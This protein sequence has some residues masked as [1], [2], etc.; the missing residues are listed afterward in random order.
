M[1]SQINIQNRLALV[2]WGSV[3]LAYL[4]AAVG[5]A[6]YQSVTLESRAQRIM[7]PYAQ[8]ISVGSDAAI[9]FQDPQRA[10][11]VLDTLR[12]NPQILQA[13][14]YLDNGHILA[15]FSH[16]DK[17][18][19]HITTQR[20]DGIYIEENRVE[21][22]QSLHSGAHLLISMDLAQL[23]EQ[24]R[25]AIWLFAAGAFILLLASIAQFAVLR[26]MIVQ[27]IATLTR[28]AEH[29]RSSADFK[30]RVPASG[31]DEVARLGQSF[32]AMM[33]VIHEKQQLLLEA[34][35]IA[36]VGNWWHDPNSGE[37]FW[38][39][40]VFNI[41][42]LDALTPS[43]ELVYQLIHH[44]DIEILQKAIRLSQ[45]SHEDSEQEFRILR[46]NGETRWV[47]NRWVS[48]FDNNGRVIKQIGTLQDITERKE[49]EQALHQL[50]RELRAI[51]EC[52]HI[53]IRAEQEQ[54]LI[55]SVCRII[56]E[57]AGYRLAWVGYAEH[58]TAK[59]IRPVAWAG[60][61]DGY[62]AQVPINWDD[63]AYG[64]GP[65]GL[66]IR[67][68][69]IHVVDDFTTDPGTRPWQQAALQRG[70]NSSISLPLKNDCGVTFGVLGIFS[71]ASNAFPEPEQRLLEELANDLAFG[72]DTLRTRA[73][74]NQAEEQIRIAATAFEAQEGII[75]ADVNRQILR[76][77]RAFTE[78]SGYSAQEVMGKTPQLLKS[79]KHDEEFFSAMWQSLVKE[80]VWQG[81]IWN[82]DKQGDD[83]PVWLNIT[84]VRDPSGQVTHYVGTMTDITERKEAEKKIEHL[85]YYDLLTELPNRR[86]LLDR[87]RQASL[88]SLRSKNMGA[89][90]FI[91]L[92]NFKILNDTSGHDIGDKLLIGVAR[93]LGSCVRDGDTISRLGGDE[94]VVILEDLSQT[95]AEAAAHAK[96]IG[97]KIISILNQ[98]YQIEDRMHHSTPSIGIT[99]FNG[100]ENSVDDLLK[101]ADIAMYQAK[102]AGR[103]TLRFF[104]PEMQANLAV[105]ADT[106]AELR[107]SIQHENFVLHY[108]PQV[109][110]NNRIIAAE[111]LVRWPHP[112]KG[113]MSPGEFIPL[114]EETGLILPLGQWVLENACQQ[115]AIWSRDPDKQHLNLAV[116]VSAKQF[117]EKDFT[118]RVKQVLKT[119]GAPANRLKLELTETLVLDNVQGSIEK[120]HTLKE[121]GVGFSMDDFG[122]G[123]SSL[124]YLTRLPLDQ[125]KIDRSFI[126]NLP[127]NA[128][129]AVVVQTIIMMAGSLG[130]KLIAEGV[131]TDAQRVFLAQQGCFVYQGYL[132]SKPVELSAFETLMES[133]KRLN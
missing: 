127:D 86:L 60:D 75:I 48:V 64:N 78:I 95:P 101:Q 70:Y 103:N 111:A 79:E 46:P 106:E 62:L 45:Q 29:V 35:H 129:D 63:S 23:N 14:I 10:Q 112:Q 42:G 98:P 123:Y 15:S 93:R 19:P 3:L 17:S 27:P 104:D 12:A 36:H 39:E 94:F 100:S 28:A 97:G 121:L 53:L 88:G 126:R 84:A 31:N 18:M 89:L 24:T 41:L 8:L 34:Q 9:A 30:Y 92:D 128:N 99:L 61:E 43:I 37:I 40:E 69:K 108:Q 56:C 1:F 26:R 66:T 47:N 87:L 85:A 83:Y 58:D 117:R 110:E 50:N 109:D 54:A 105:R 131:E 5:L 90:L 55:E 32:N 11:E 72:I 115:L 6:T 133:D 91:D 25:Q 80:G 76:V 82:R 20:A 49:S 116:N 130:L 44:D 68:G 7:Q 107:R 120:M 132:F 2:L 96:L 73:Q 114:A 113:L 81:E 71:S 77:N 4:V 67:H 65:S 122:T 22:L 57:D 59:T 51:T 124:S 119:T 21:L 16:T 102:T 74:H 125:L 118:Y 38:S 52:N 33:G 13:G